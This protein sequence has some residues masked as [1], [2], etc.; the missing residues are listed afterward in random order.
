[1][2]KTLLYLL[3]F[4][5]IVLAAWFGINGIETNTLNKT[6]TA[7]TLEDTASVTK[8]IIEDNEGRK[9]QLDKKEALWVVNQG[10]KARPDAIQRLLQTLTKLQVKYPVGKDAYPAVMKNFENPVRRVSIFKDNPN[11]AS[12]VYL[13][14]GTPHT[15]KGTYMMLEGTDDPYVVH[16]LGLEG[17]LMTRFFTVPETWRDR[18]IM[19]FRASDL[20]SV[21][22]EYPHFEESSF[23]VKAVADS[24]VVESLGG[25]MAINAADKLNKPV[26]V[27]FLSSFEKVN[28]EGFENGYP[29]IDSVKASKPFTKINIQTKSGKSKEITIHYMPLNRR[30]KAQIDGQGK[31]VPYDVDR[32]FAFVNGGKDFVL[33]QRRTFEG[34]F[35][36]LSDFYYTP[37]VE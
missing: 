4:L 10:Y 2:N 1:M 28:L 24:F 26:L 31:A 8:V 6:T 32:F 5:A 20:A 29:R 11:E 12:K 18:M 9:L 17:H 7:F 21:R 36:R 15:L 13:L 27:K 30:S 14:G 16:L 35:K 23:E 3:V 33:I 19:D 34:M 22:V 25:K 37:V